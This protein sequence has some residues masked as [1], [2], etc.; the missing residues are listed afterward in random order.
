MPDALLAHEPHDLV[1]GRPQVDVVDGGGHD[2]HH[3]EV[4]GGRAFA[5]HELDDVPLGEDAL[6]ALAV[7]HQQEAH[8]LLLQEAHGVGDLGFGGDE[9]EGIALRVQDALHVGHAR[10]SSGLDQG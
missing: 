4:Q 6:H 2:L 9:E 7:H 8:L 3:L 1:H 5:G 10:F